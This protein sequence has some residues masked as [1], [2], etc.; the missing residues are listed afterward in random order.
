M[1][2]ECRTEIEIAAPP[3][4]VWSILVDVNQWGEWNP[5]VTEASGESALGSKLKIGMKNESGGSGPK[6]AATITS[7]DEPTLFRW[8]AT[9]MAGF[10]F[11][12]DKV[13]EL[14]ATDGG[15]RLVHK[16]LFSGL[17]VSMMWSKLESGV[18]PMLSKMN[19]ALKAKA[20]QA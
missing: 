19:E 6:Y 10:L 2:R 15:C 13:V 16:E 8:R 3:E 14:E 12:N 5:I 4:K 11:T 1:M 18:G 9:M 17:M 20:E 7:F